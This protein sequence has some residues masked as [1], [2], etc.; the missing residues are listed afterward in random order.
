MAF[1][2]DEFGKRRTM[3]YL[4]IVRTVDAAT[5]PIT[6]A[7][8]KTQLRITGSSFDTEIDGLIKV[9]RQEA[10]QYCMR[11]FITQTWKLYLNDWPSSSS[12]IKLPYGRLISV[13]SVKYTVSTQFDTEI[14]SSNYSVGSGDIGIIKPIDSWPETDTDFPRSIEIEYTAGYGDATTVPETIKQAIKIMLTDYF[15]MRSSYVRGSAG[16]VSEGSPNIRSEEML[17]ERLLGKYKIYF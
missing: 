2:E 8:A 13:T 14:D 16:K 9:A 7:E 3:P 11:S 12:I 1:I 10:E 6:T 17:Y 5:E 15:E 4:D